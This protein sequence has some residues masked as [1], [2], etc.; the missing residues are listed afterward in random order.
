MFIYSIYTYINK[1]PVHDPFH[2]N[3]KICLCSKFCH[4]PEPWPS[5]SPDVRVQSQS[6]TTVVI[7][8]H[9][10]ICE[11]IYIYIYYIDFPCWVRLVALALPFRSV[12]FRCSF[13][14]S[15]VII[16]LGS[17][18]VACQPCLRCCL[19]LPKRH[20]ESRS[21]KLLDRNTG[22]LLFI[23]SGQERLI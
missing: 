14:R 15:K 20:S 1:H 21:Q 6:Y 12:D 16:T 9:L 23:S 7:Q 22:S 13:G 3:K 10:T 11:Y 18:L 5:L 4:S 8:F 2:E 19:R 17:R